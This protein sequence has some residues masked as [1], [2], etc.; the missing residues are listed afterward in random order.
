M[1]AA[2]AVGR[3]IQ[4]RT[5]LS[6]KKFLQALRPLQSALI[7]TGTHTITV[8]PRPSRPRPKR[9]ST[10]SPAGACTNL[11][12]LGFDRAGARDQAQKALSLND[13]RA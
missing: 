7:N 10:F 8:P 13:R 3:T 9:Y 11:S 12:Q 5:G 1:F 6:I 2:L 4:A